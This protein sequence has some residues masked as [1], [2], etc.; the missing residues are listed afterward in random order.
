MKRPTKR[1][2]AAVRLNARELVRKLR[3][4]N[5]PDSGV[6]DIE[7]Q[8]CEDAL[9]LSLVRGPLREDLGAEPDVARRRRDT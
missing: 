3:E 6:T 7:Y 9:V 2:I 5:G 1:Q 4:S 8:M